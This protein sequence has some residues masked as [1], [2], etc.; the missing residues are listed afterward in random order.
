MLSF[1]WS[2]WRRRRE[3]LAILLLGIFIVGGGL[4]FLYGL[5]ESNKGTVMET[6]QRKWQVSYDIAVRPPGTSFGDEAAGLMEPNFQDGIDGGISM[7]QLEQIKGVPGVSIAAPLA[8]LGYAN[9]GTDLGRAIDFKEYGIYR[10][11]KQVTANN[12]V[13]NLASTYETTYAWNGPSGNSVWELWSN[14]PALLVA[15]DPAEEAK[16]VGLDRAV[17]PMLTS[18]Y[19][20]ETDTSQVQVTGQPMAGK[21]SFVKLPILISNQERASQTY[22]YR[23]EKLDVPYATAEDEAKLRAISKAAGGKDILG[24]AKTLWSKSVTVENTPERATAELEAKLVSS[25]SAPDFM[26]L[27][28]RAKP[29]AYEPAVSPYPGHWPAAYRV[30]AFDAQDAAERGEFPEYYRP[31][32][33][34][35]DPNRPDAAAD[36]IGLFVDYIGMYDPAKLRVSK[37]VDSLF[38]MD[39]YVAPSA[40]LIFDPAGRPANPPATIKPVSNPLGLLTSPPTMLTTMEAAAL[41]AGDRPISVVRVK[42]N[43]GGVSDLRQAELERVAQAIR[44]RTGLEADVMLGSS[45]QPVLVQVPKSGA[46]TEIGW[47]E[48][49]WIKLGAALTLVNEVKLGFSGMLLLVLLI[50]V[51]YVVATN[52]VSFLARKREYAVLLAIGWRTSRIR[53]LLLLEAACVGLFAALVTWGME[54]CL[55]WA[56][57]SSLSAPRFAATGLGAFGL[58][59]LGAAVP[60]AQAGRI[61]PLAALRT[62]E[63]GSTARRLLPASGLLG[64]AAANVAGKWRRNLL[65][66]LSMALPTALLMFFVFV[67]FRLKGVFYTSWLG[68]YA[69]A[70]IGFRHYLAIGVCLLIAVLT[71]AELMWQNVSERKPEIALLKAIGWRNRTVRRLILTEGAVAGG[72]AG[73]VAFA[74]GLLLIAMLY[75]Q[76]PFREMGC[77]LA[78]AVL[79]VLTG[80]LGSALP[81]RSA[82]GR[83][84]ARGLAGGD[85]Q[86]AREQAVKPGKPEA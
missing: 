22:T 64:L 63:Y 44:E 24:D 5:T 21:T 53:R 25:Q 70:E 72:L 23:Y 82:A 42:V 58:F 61:E 8:V 11:K 29:L 36:G 80:A 68:Q 67:T 86:A 3:R 16:L 13:Q 49:L 2:D 52:M 26:F 1:V 75:R 55:L 50:A 41:I 79:P 40:K 54:A 59:V 9:F 20:N 31:F 71:T 78:V 28:V 34:V 6:L 10:L 15:V 83:S 45:P 33:G 57:G 35:K 76:L 17:L 39:T 46:Q 47:M 60:V 32:E 18:H 81:A 14:D 66:V 62:G 65:A 30:K 74:L 51:L 56:D 85:V 84:P 37:D 19:F 43:G 77:L 38:P 69:A 27:N 12:G 4:S 48:Q 73:V 7:K